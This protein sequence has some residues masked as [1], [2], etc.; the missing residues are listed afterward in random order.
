MNTE[1]Y[2]EKLLVDAGWYRGRKV[3]VKR[4][5][6]AIRSAAKLNAD[7]IIQEFGGLHIGE[8]G[9]GREQSASDISF[10]NASYEFSNEFWNQWPELESELY[11]FASAHNSH[12]HLFVND[13]NEIYIFTDP[14]EK[15][16]LG[17]S[18][19]ETM[20]KLLLGLKYGSELEKA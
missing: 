17:G 4:K 2:I 12:I 19:T 3:K 11:S 18:L 14:D 6:F 9:V 10:R 16:Y 15:L 20:N 13:H 5:L 8:V 1:Q 7:K